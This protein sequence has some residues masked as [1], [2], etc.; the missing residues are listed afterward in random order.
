MYCSCGVEPNAFGVDDSAAEL[1]LF[2][3]QIT[4]VGVGLKPLRR[5]D[6][7]GIF[8]IFEKVVRTVSVPENFIQ[9][10]AEMVEQ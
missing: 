4:F 5:I 6:D 10:D 1:N 8:E 7:K 2:R 9:P 3:H